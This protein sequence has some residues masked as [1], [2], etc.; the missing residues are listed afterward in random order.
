MTKLM[1]PE[2]VK[3][4]GFTLRSYKQ[5]NEKYNILYLN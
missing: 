1:E 2:I 5:E 3:K 4:I